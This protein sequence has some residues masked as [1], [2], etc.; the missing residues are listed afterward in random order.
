MLQ[1]FIKKDD[2]Y[3]N[4]SCDIKKRM[5]ILKNIQEEKMSQENLNIGKRLELKYIFYFFYIKINTNNKIK[6]NRI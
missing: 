2:K 3:L 4:I 6:K 1:V 5:G